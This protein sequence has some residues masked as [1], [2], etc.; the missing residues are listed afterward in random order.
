MVGGGVV[1]WWWGG[2]ARSGGHDG[3]VAIEIHGAWLPQLIL[4]LCVMWLLRG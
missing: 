1:W 2:V 4:R 3:N